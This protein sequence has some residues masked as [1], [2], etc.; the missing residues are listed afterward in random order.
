VNLPTPAVPSL[1]P[2]VRSFADPPTPRAL[3]SDGVECGAGREHDE[4]GQQLDLLR[5]SEQRFR[6]VFANAPTGIA[7][8]DWEGCILECNPAYGGLVGRAEADLLGENFASL[9]YPDDRAVNLA[10]MNRL[11]EGELEY[12]EIE[13][14]YLRPDGSIVWVHKFVSVLDAE[15]SPPTLMALVSDVTE[16]RQLDELLRASEE[17]FRTMFDS[18][19]AGVAHVA[20]DGSFV[21]VNPAFCSITGR[22]ESDLIRLRFHDITHPDDLDADLAHVERLLAGEISRYSM[23]KRYL[24]PDG[25]S[26][27]INLTGSLAR[28]PSGEADYFVAVVEDITADVA[29]QSAERRARAEAELTTEVASRLE[30]VEG[31]AE[32]AT[33]LVDALVPVFAS[34]GYIESTDDPPR[35]LATAGDMPGPEEIRSRV[36]DGGAGRSAHIEAPL[37]LGGGRRGVLAVGRADPVAE[38]YTAQ[39]SEFLAGLAER[40]GLLIASAHLRDQEHRV[41]LRLQRALLPDSLASA[42]TLE[43]AARYL[44]AAEILEV[45]GDW[46]DSIALPD[47]RLLLVVGDVVGHGVDA[48]ADMGRLR[49]GLV[50]LAARDPRPGHLLVELDRFASG[51]NGVEFATVCCALIDPGSGEV[52]YSSAGHPPMLVL[53]PGGAVRWLDDARSVP[54]CSVV[55]EHR[56]DATTRLDP[57]STLVLF[58]DGLFERR[59]EALTV[60]LGRIAEAGSELGR[61]SAQEVCDGLIDELTRAVAVEDDIVVLAARFRPDR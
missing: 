9:V 4:P 60:G 30:A 23:P 32:R 46:Y 22:P 7:I 25:A 10:E 19:A 56:P 40:V 16:R 31:A 48:A 11:K 50:A 33:R 55:A 29:R 36:D 61:A 28:S 20:L 59:G 18:A 17:H 43:V 6:R 53:S 38:P 5:R 49:A 15:A 39:D 2:A 26:V 41:S 58:S 8:T 57:R 35:L 51:P 12:L 24:R 34:Y 13:N 42:E 47:G 52:T 1:R 54:L 27:W 3:S 14:R 37:D 45:G 44:A 21:R